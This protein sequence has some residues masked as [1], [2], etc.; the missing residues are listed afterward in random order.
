MA[1]QVAVRRIARKYLRKLKTDTL[2]QKFLDVIYNDIAL[3]PQN[4]I[5][6]YGDLRH[7]YSWKL[8]D[9]GTEYRLAYEIMEANTIDIVLIGTRENFYKQLKK[10]LKTVN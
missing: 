6:K 10:Y 8:M 2:R 5:S 3:A 1:Y 9:N 4:G 7:I